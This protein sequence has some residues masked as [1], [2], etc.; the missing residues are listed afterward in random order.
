VLVNYSVTFEFPER[1]SITHRG[2]VV[3]STMPT[4]FARATREAA[5]AHPGLRWSSIVCVLLER[6]DMGSEDRIVLRGGPSEKSSLDLNN[7]GPVTAG[8]STTRR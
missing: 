7:E 2:T 3:G 8:P 1:A 6:V 5:K 4:C